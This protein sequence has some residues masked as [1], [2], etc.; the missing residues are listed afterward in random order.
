MN[1]I[2]KNESEY[3]K[4]KLLEAEFQEKL[5]KYSVLS[6][7]LNNN[8]MGYYGESKKNKNKNI[9]VTN[10]QKSTGMEYLGCVTKTDV[11]GLAEQTDM[12]NNTTFNSCKQRAEDLGNKYFAKLGMGKNQYPN[13]QWSNDSS[14]L[15]TCPDGY[16]LESDKLVIN[17]QQ[18][19][20]RLAGG[21]YLNGQYFGYNGSTKKWHSGI[22]ISGKFVDGET[23]VFHEIQIS[24]NGNTLMIYASPSLQ[25]SKQYVLYKNDIWCS[26]NKLPTGCPGK[27]RFGSYT[28]QM[29]S[30]W[31]NL[32]QTSWYNKDDLEKGQTATLTKKGTNAYISNNKSLPGI[33][34][35][36]RCFVGDNLDIAGSNLISNKCSQNSAGQN[37]GNNESMAVY[38]LNNINKDL[39]KNLGKIGYVD[40]RSK[41]HEYPE[42]M[43]KQGNT[44]KLFNNFDSFGNDLS[45]LTNVNVNNCK[46]ECN[47][48]DDCYG[49]VYN[50]NNK[51]CFLKNKKMYPTGLRLANNDRDLYLRNKEVNNNKSCSKDIE[52]VNVKAWSGFSKGEE[53]TMSK[54]C[55]LGEELG[56][57]KIKNMISNLEVEL[58]YLAKEIQNEIKSLSSVDSKLAEDIKSDKTIMDNQLKEYTRIRR[59]IKENRDNT[60]LLQTY[61]AQMEKS[62]LAINM[63]F[64]KMAL[65]SGLGL[66]ALF[67]IYKFTGR[68]QI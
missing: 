27:A 45:S 35:T 12:V 32:C 61:D 34:L 39:N 53:M 4:L 42:N 10:G 36:E 20:D 63:N 54:L 28:N 67:S 56:T 57:N 44:Y 30:K 3:N 52:D 58:D 50:R 31:G 1:A 29:K 47:K 9:S 11:N 13:T 64:A 24:A 62:D 6:Q 40:F 26:P 23:N 37:I 5:N 65:Y 68:K 49:F 51:N 60:D 25:G 46:N 66:M 43:I 22:N 17:T 18:I 16:T 41:L 21:L 14:K 55:G 48:T 8:L 38:K 7:Q 19:P 2:Q 15:G 33:D 59:K